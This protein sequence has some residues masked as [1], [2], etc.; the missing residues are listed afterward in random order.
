LQADTQ[1]TVTMLCIAGLH[2]L[3][4]KIKRNKTRGQ[5]KKKRKK[6]LIVKPFVGYLFLQRTYMRQIGD[7]EL[8][9]DI[10][11]C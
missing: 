11:Y 3:D 7:S 2:V 5:I 4:K 8:S 6:R 9:Y 1:T 10:A